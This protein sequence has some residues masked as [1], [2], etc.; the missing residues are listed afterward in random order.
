MIAAF[1]EIE[2]A[3]ISG[4]VLKKQCKTESPFTRVAAVWMLQWFKE[5]HK[6]FSLLLIGFGKSLS[7]HT[8]HLATLCK[9]MSSALLHTIRKPYIVPNL[10]NRQ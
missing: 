3:S 6:Q 5:L 10:L 9:Q 8:F 7:K 4:V 1:D 2:A